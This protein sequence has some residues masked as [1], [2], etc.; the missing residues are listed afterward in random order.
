MAIVAFY[1]KIVG[2]ILWLGNIFCLNLGTYSSEARQGC[3]FYALMHDRIMRTPLSAL[4]HYH[5]AGTLFRSIHALASGLL[6][7]GAIISFLPGFIFLNA[8]GFFF[9]VLPPSKI[10][11]V[12]S[13]SVQKRIESLVHTPGGL[14]LS[15]GVFPLLC[16]I[17]ALYSDHVWVDVL[18]LS[19]AGLLLLWYFACFGGYWLKTTSIAVTTF[20]IGILFLFVSALMAG[21]PAY[22]FAFL[23]GT[24][25]CMQGYFLIQEVQW[26]RQHQQKMSTVN[27]V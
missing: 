5:P 7:L 2:L 3:S 23:E 26:L 22:P 6:T 17:P 16:A 12:L 20:F 25:A 8:G 13:V 11:S 9:A 10:V 18:Q 21:P 1:L 14:V 4:H 27:P 24:A 15:M 19:G